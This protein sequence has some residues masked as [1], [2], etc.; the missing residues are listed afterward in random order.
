MIGA[1]LFPCF[2]QIGSTNLKYPRA[3]LQIDPLTKRIQKALSAQI[4][5]QGGDYVFPVKENQ[6]RL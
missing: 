6:L 2:D 5:N 4:I 3:N 1:S